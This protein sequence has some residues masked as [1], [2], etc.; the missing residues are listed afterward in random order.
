MT[1]PYATSGTGRSGCGRAARGPRIQPNSRRA[2]ERRNRKDRNLGRN[3][4]ERARHFASRYNTRFEWHDRSRRYNLA[5]CYPNPTT[6]FCPSQEGGVSLHLHNAVGKTRE[7]REAKRGRPAAYRLWFPRTCVI[8]RAESMIFA[9]GWEVGGELCKKGAGAADED[10]TR[11]NIDKESA[12]SAFARMACDV[13]W[14]SGT[15][16]ARKGRSAM[17]PLMSPS[18]AS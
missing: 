5:K 7:Q 17:R 1:D 4:E 16:S 10:G 9:K 2:Y 15:N 8:E 11:L 12:H 14:S 13:L 6:P 3:G 18:D